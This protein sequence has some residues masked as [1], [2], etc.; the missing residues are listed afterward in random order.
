MPTGITWSGGGS[1]VHASGGVT[2]VATIPSGSYG[3][4]PIIVVGMASFV[5]SATSNANHAVEVMVSG[6]SI[7]GPGLSSSSVRFPPTGSVTV[8]RRGTG[9]LAGATP[10]DGGATIRVTT[11]T[12]GVAAGAETGG[13]LAAI[14]SI[15]GPKPHSVNQQTN[16]TPNGSTSQTGTFFNDYMDAAGGFYDSDAQYAVGMISTWNDSGQLS[17]VPS[18]ANLAHWGQIATFQSSAGTDGGKA[19]MSLGLYTKPT[20]WV[21]TWSITNKAAGDVQGIHIVVWATDMSTYVPP[22]G[23]TNVAIVG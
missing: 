21:S 7:G 20:P 23:V 15:D 11:N 9:R 3:N 2:T 18:W 10:L 12:T 5:A 14:L 19:T 16:P 17:R 4:N 8:E 13:V 6:S 22:G 1:F